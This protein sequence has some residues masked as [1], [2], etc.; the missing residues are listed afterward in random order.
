MDHD[1]P[2]RRGRR[3]ERGARLA[4]VHRDARGQAEPGERIEAER[5]PALAVIVGH[6][7][8]L[9]EPHARV[10]RG[11]VARQHAL[12]ARVERG[13]VDARARGVGQVGE[14]DGSRVA[15][16]RPHRRD[17]VAEARGVHR[18]VREA[19]HEA[20]DAQRAKALD[21][22]VARV[23]DAR[24]RD[25][26]VERLDLARAGEVRGARR[27]GLGRRRRRGAA[28]EGRQGE[29][30]GNARDR[31]PRDGTAK[32]RRRRHPAIAL[33]VNARTGQLAG[34]FVARRTRQAPMCTW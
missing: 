9:D 4:L 17:E 11:K 27:V 31:H 21:A 5:A 13:G 10:L 1:G 25:G 30:R 12:G 29:E 2:V 34:P 28:G 3:G 6:D 16:E 14:L 24:R 26:G 22:R 32:R 15:I 33:D 19:R 18:R 8:R 23:G 20:V 7:G